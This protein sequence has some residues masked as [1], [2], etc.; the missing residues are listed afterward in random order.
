MD[1]YV[2]T[3]ARGY[4]S[5]GKFIGTKLAELLGIPLIDR[6]LLYLAS[7]TSGINEELFELWDEK[8]RTKFFDLKK[9]KESENTIPPENKK[10]T[11]NDNLFK[12]QAKVLRSMAKKESFIVIGRAANYILRSQPNVISVNI[13]APFNVCVKSI[14]E[15]KFV[16]QEQAEKDIQTIDKYR[17][18]YYEYYTGLD[19]QDIDCFDLFLN[20]D[21]IGRNK[22]VD[23]IQ[24][25][26]EQKL[27]RKIGK[28]K[29]DT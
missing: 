20:S 21:R 25:F 14:I 8:T 27:G 4:G 13:Q 3:I 9:F 16:P 18:K 12:Y 22:C 1:N 24:D 10:F 7:Q 6:E 23:V 28:I 17:H 29:G 11:S 15:K 19:W 5:G 26:T 2:I